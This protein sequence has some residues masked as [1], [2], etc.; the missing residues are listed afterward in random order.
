MNLIK[1]NRRSFLKLL[2]GTN[3]ES[4][5][6][7]LDLLEKFEHRVDELE[8]LVIATNEVL[9]EI[10]KEIGPIGRRNILEAAISDISNRI[11]SI[12]EIVQYHQVAFT[13]IIEGED[14]AYTQLAL[15]V[16]P[17]NKDRLN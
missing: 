12:T 13:E 4:I 5:H 6:K 9:I 3:I 11:S 15:S 1:K 16:G 2:F 14:A 17:V 7:Q 8:G 10:A